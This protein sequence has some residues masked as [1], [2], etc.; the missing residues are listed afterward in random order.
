[1]FS[2]I[3]P[4]RIRCYRVRF[5]MARPVSYFANWA[6]RKRHQLKVFGMLISAASRA[7]GRNPLRKSACH[8]G[9]KFSF[10]PHKHWG[11]VPRDRSDSYSLLR[12]FSGRGP[13]I[14]APLSEVKRI[15]V[16]SLSVFL[17]L[18]E[19]VLHPDQQNKRKRSNYL[20][21]DCGIKLLLILLRTRIIIW[22]ITEHY[23]P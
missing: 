20:L 4:V 10:P 1:M 7:V 8:T 2:S 11:V 14:T 13:S 19:C 18:F 3:K 15:I 6:A 17:Q 21:F 9:L 5:L 16:L 23:K 12:P 22:Q